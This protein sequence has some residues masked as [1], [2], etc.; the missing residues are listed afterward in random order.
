MNHILADLNSGAGE[1]GGF[2]SALRTATANKSQVFEY[3]AASSLATNTRENQS[4]VSCDNDVVSS[5]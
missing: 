5:D 4:A 3:W 1:D 2:L